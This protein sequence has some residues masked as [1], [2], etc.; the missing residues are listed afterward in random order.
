[1]PVAYRVP[2][3][4]RWQAWKRLCQQRLNA[5]LLLRRLPQDNPIIAPSLRQ[6]SNWHE[7]PLLTSP[8]GTA[9]HAVLYGC[10]WASSCPSIDTV[11]QHEIC[12]FL[13]NATFWTMPAASGVSMPVLARSV[14]RRLGLYGLLQNHLQHEPFFTQ[15]LRRDAAYLHASWRR[16][17]R[18]G[19]HIL[20]A[21]VSIIAEAC[22][23]APDDAIDKSLSGLYKLLDEQF[24]DNGE[25][26]S[27]N[28]SLQLYL[29]DALE[30]LREVLT[31]RGLPVD[32]TLRY[33][34]VMSADYLRAFRQD[35]GGFPMFNGSFAEPTAVINSILNAVPN[36]N[37]TLP[38]SRTGYVQLRG[39]RTTVVADFGRAP[40]AAYSHDMHAGLFAFEMSFG[41][42]RIIVNCG[43]GLLLG[44]PWD[45]AL[46]QTAAHSTLLPQ[47]PQGITAPAVQIDGFVTR[48][49]AQ[50][51]HKLMRPA[52]GPVVEGS[53][54]GWAK[55]GLMHRRRL[56]VHADGAV[57]QGEDWL[58]RVSTSTKE[59]SAVGGTFAV[60]FHLHPDIDAKLI[61]SGGALL[62][63]PDG[64]HWLMIP[65]A[66]PLA[67][68]ESVYVER[69]GHVR[70]SKQLVLSGHINRD[71]T[72]IRWVLQN[73]RTNTPI[74]E[75]TA[76]EV[77]QAVADSV[78]EDA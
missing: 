45:D 3:V 42:Q 61:K 62:T 70:A 60:R 15:T 1:M 72:K 74:A 16:D 43:S 57:V 9:A 50:I 29:V 75:H 73:V 52:R 51:H 46:R 23:D 11:Q 20:G 34:L 39:K 54:N 67:I 59:A 63:L 44:D 38:T 48:S 27:R 41:A 56:V 32:T 76:E 6:G 18:A 40:D 33:A 24:L 4:S 47:A 19:Y 77:P 28:F 31:K 37:E 13:C 25:H 26:V 68:E 17:P 36:R 22:F 35:D 78:L 21:T 55:C 71:E 49:P 64:R 5:R 58:T 14:L 66:R 7:R 30:A 12:S 65:G 10:D 53:H 69:D 2:S 8:L